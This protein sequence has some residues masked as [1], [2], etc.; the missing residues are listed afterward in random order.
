VTPAEQVRFLKDRCRSS[1]LQVV[2]DLYWIYVRHAP[3]WEEIRR[4]DDAGKWILR[5]PADEKA[6][7]ERAEAVLP[8]VGD[9]AVRAAKFTNLSTPR[10]PELKDSAVILAYCTGPEKEKLRALVEPLWGADIFWKTNRET[11]KA[12]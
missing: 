7:L 2:P 6:L 5:L 11:F 12:K 10:R 1:S 9:G 8:L 3:T 4:R